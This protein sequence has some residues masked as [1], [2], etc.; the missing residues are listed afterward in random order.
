M[1]E[2]GGGGCTTKHEGQLAGKKYSKKKKKIGIQI[3]TETIVKR[4]SE[5]NQARSDI[6]AQAAEEAVIFCNPQSCDRLVSIVVKASALRA[7]DLGFKSRL[8]R[9]FSE[10]SHTS[11]LGCTGCLGRGSTFVNPTAA[12]L[13]MGRHWSSPSTQLSLL[14]PRKLL[15][16][17]VA[18]PR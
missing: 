18:T 12:S 6:M 7:E 8:R 10:Q 2:G 17:T 15:G 5:S 13:G 4:T 14:A 11:D 1:G 9:D 16:I 3:R